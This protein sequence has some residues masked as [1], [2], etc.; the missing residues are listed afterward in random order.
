LDVLRGIAALAVVYHHA[1]IW[2][3]TR[4]HDAV[5]RWFDAGVFGTTLFFLISGYLIPASLDRKGSL[6]TFWVSRL[7]RLYPLWIAALVAVALLRHT[8]HWNVGDA[9]RY[10]RRHPLTFT[11]AHGTMF[12]DLLDVPNAVGV[13]WTL[14]YEMFFYC[15]VAGLFVVGLARFTG[16][17]ALL[18]AVGGTVLWQTLPYGWLS[19]RLG[20]G[21]VAAA[22]AG[23]FVAGLFAILTGRHTWS[24]VG[25]LALGGLSLVLFWGDRGYPWDGLL[26]PAYLFLGTTIHRAQHG[27]IQVRTAWAVALGVFGLAILTGVRHAAT[28]SPAAQALAEGRHW[29]SAVTVAGLLFAVGLALQD[30][31]MPRSLRRLGEIS[32]SVYLLHLILLQATTG[33]LK[34]F[35]DR[36]A[37][38]HHGR[39]L[40]Q[41]VTAMVTVLLVVCLLAELTYRLI[42]A[43]M[44]RVGRR[45]AETLDRVLGPDVAA[46]APLRPRLR[47]ARVSSAT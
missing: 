25:A 11:L 5:E 20:Q 34:P 28:L 19:E 44:Q 17:I 10:A 38:H 32:F 45:V 41:Q 26:I 22:V 37:L 1:G 2:V 8:G 14:S 3:L 42:E 27:R 7:F 30:R 29:A 36:Y 16:R 47:R 31:A 39:P 4:P 40:W 24:R 6:R 12:Q 43:P 9:D 46:L 35:G 18:F 13:M 33:Q 23:L 15:L 21:R